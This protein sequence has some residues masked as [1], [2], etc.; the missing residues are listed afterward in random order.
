M[1]AG[2]GAA[3]VVRPVVDVAHAMLRARLCS[4][5]PAVDLGVV[6]GE[7]HVGHL[8]AAELRR[9]RVVRILDAAV[10]RGAEGLVLARALRERSGQPARDRVDQ[11]HRRQLAAGEDVRADRD[12]VGAEVVDDARVESLEAGRE[13]RDRRLRGELLDERLV[14]LAALRR[15]RDHARG[16]VVAVGRLERGRDDIDAQHH[17]RAAAVGRVVD[18]AGAQRRRVPVVE[19][20][21]LELGAEDGGKR[22]LLGQ[23]A[24]GMRNLGE[25]VET[26]PGQGIGQLM[27]PGLRSTTPSAGSI[28][29]IASSIIGTSVP[30]SS[31]RLSLAG[32]GSTSLDDSE[33][34][35]RPPLR[36]AGR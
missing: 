11:H 1:S 17:A 6:P 12:R 13:H 27:K 22:L 20:P 8:P 5:P 31:S 2:D 10:E 15:Q 19:E 4:A 23:P 3:R 28:E 32:P 25:D 14:E 7:E 21:K 29:R 36:R 24:E 35:V 16:P 30:S 34:R 18:L 9:T 33:R 26:H